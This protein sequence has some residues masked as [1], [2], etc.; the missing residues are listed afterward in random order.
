MTDMK[1][2]RASA[3]Y[4]FAAVAV[5]TAGCASHRVGHVSQGPV[6]ALPH[7]DAGSAG[8]LERFMSEVRR[9]TAVSAVSSKS[10]VATRLET[11]NVQLRE[12]LAEVQ[13]RDSTAARHRAGAVYLHLGIRDAAFDQYK[14]AIRLN[15]R[16]AAAYDAL[17]RLWRDWGWLSFA[18]SDAYRAVYYAPR[19]AEAH[20]TLGTILAALGRRDQA[21]VVFQRAAWLDPGATWAAMNLCRVAAEGRTGT[22][23]FQCE[24]LA[25]LRPAA[26]DTRGIVSVPPAAARATVPPTTVGATGPNGSTATAAPG[27]RPGPILDPSPK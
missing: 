19:S 12:A 13:A 20:N 26:V 17:A 25:G 3:V 8:D 21:R 15:P 7:V 27:S 16:D 14:A 10:N 18:L 24:S 6:P 23:P 4:C 11:S 1:L 2:R 22:V 9:A 5:L